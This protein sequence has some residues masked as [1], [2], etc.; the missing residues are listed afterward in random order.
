MGLTVTACPL[1]PGPGRVLIGVIILTLNQCDSTLRCLASLRPGRHP[2]RVLVW[3]N[4][5][6][7]GTVDTVRNAFP[8]VLTH[9]HPANLGVAS[10]RNA[11]AELLVRELA[12]THLLFLDNDMIVE[13]GFVDALVQPML[14]DPRI[15]QTQAKLRFMHDPERLNDGGGCSIDWLL[16]RTVPVGFEEIDRGQY[17]TPKRCVACGGAMMVRAEPFE[18]LG[19]FDDRFSPF[20]PEDID[21]SLRLSEAG[22]IALYVPGAVAYHQVTHTFGQGYGEDYAR[23]KSRHWLML[24]RRH[25]SLPQ[26]L[27]F[28]LL[29]APYLALR[30]I[31]REA[32]RGN[33]KAVRGT[34]RGLLDFV[35]SSR[36]PRGGHRPTR[37]PGRGTEP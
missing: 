25:A 21:F 36:G 5:S 9:R 37:P 14:D 27:G 4:G 19:G 15:G 34:L 1:P 11:A 12:P 26:K 7:D 17:D 30:I 20:G 3:D 13:E 2:Y 6:Q 29:G 35:Q 8:T 22:Y 28:Y 10:G 18:A 33:L 31:A 24:M 16:G 23:H 32:R